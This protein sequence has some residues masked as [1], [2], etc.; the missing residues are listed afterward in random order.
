[1]GRA[2][3]LVDRP[4]QPSP[5]G[6]HSAIRQ[7]RWWLRFQH[8]VVV[9]GTHAVHYRRALRRPDE[10]WRRMGTVSDDATAVVDL[11]VRA[12]RLT[13]RVPESTGTAV[14]Q[15]RGA[16]WQRVD[17]ATW[18]D[19]PPAPI[20]LRSP[21]D[22]AAELAQPFVIAPLSPN[23]A[24]V[25][26]G[27]SVFSYHRRRDG[28]WVRSA[29]L[30]VIDPEVAPA[31]HPSDKVAQVTGELDA[32]P[33]ANR[34]RRATLSRS[35]STAGIRGTDLGV[36]V[37]H[38]GRRFL[39][40][41]DTHWT[42]PWLVTRDSIAEVVDA[43]PLPVVRFH[44]SPLWVSRATMGEYDV[45]LD[46]ISVAGQWYVFF[47]SNHFRNGVT[48]GR[49]VLA[50]ARDPHPVLSPQRRRDPLRF[51][52][53]ATVSDRHFINISAQVRPA[54]EVPGAPGDGEVVL[55]WG[56]GSYRASEL[57]LAMLPV[58]QLPQRRVSELGLRYWDGSGW[59][60]SEA[61]AV[62]LFSPAALGEISV[63]W[64]PEVGRYL[65]LSMSGPGDPAG[66]AV[67]L[68]WAEHP[69]G[70]WTQRVRLLDWVAEGMVDDVQRRFIKA[71]A[72]DP[73][74]EDLFAA[75]AR[76]TG[77]AYAP[78]LFDTRRDGTELL[79]RY[80]LSTWNPYQVVLMQHRLVPGEF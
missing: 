68:R 36:C 69:A 45:P 47:S 78:Y 34:V 73:I 6:P 76:S 28:A 46:S 38:D 55:L 51:D 39:L 70:P 32:T 59:S 42:R 19:R 53:L 29:C 74:S 62:P 48:M 54:R 60:D 13:A 67:T 3:L 12:G 30:Q 24:V 26:E 66:M 65:L 27:E 64:V 33:G 14:Y 72:G 7:R 41:G 21:H 77:G 79:L 40:F 5:I 8:V 23:A 75:Q 37:E 50:R 63:R 44:G 18:D 22:L 20:R 1:M 11:G 52:G 56:T 15:R 10:P 31:V 9:Q 4:G 49:S 80:T 2:Q 17:D 25:A 61:S 58:D 57:R 43:E 71:R 16:A 35:L